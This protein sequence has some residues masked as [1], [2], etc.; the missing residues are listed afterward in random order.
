MLSLAQ[1]GH[2]DLW[3]GTPD[4]L[5]HV[6]ANGQ[7][8]KTYTS[9]DGLPDDFIRSLLVDSQGTVWAGTRRGLA[10]LERGRI[11]VL[12]R[13]AGLPSDSIGPLL[14]SGPA[15]RG[16]LWIGS[17]GGLA[18]LREGGGMEVTTPVPEGDTIITAL[19][20]DGAGGLWV[21]VHGKGLFRWLTG[22]FTPVA[23]P[24]LPSEIT[25][26]HTDQQG[27]L[28]IRSP[29]AVYRVQAS[30]LKAC[31]GGRSCS[32]LVDEF[33]AADGMP[34]DALAAE[35]TPQI[36]EVAGGELWFSTRKG[37]AVT[38]PAHLPRRDK[39]P[40]VVVQRLTVDGVAEPVGEGDLRIGPG[41]NRYVFDYAALSFRLPSKVRYRYRLDGF[42]R[43]WVD[44]GAA[45][46]AYYT[47]LPPGRYRFRVLAANENGL[48]TDP[49][50]ALI[51]RVL[52]PVYRRWW[53]YV[54]VLLLVAAL[55]FATLRL[56]DRAVQRRFA[57]VLEERNRMAREIHDTLAQ[58]FV[59]VTLQLD[60]ASGHLRGQRYEQAAL[61]LQS[62]R[63]LVK[64]GLQAARQSIWNLRANAGERSLPTRLSIL[65]ARYSFGDRSPKVSIGGAF[66][67]LA[68]ALEDEVLR[69]A[70]ESLSNAERHA[71]ASE[72]N[73]ELRYAPDQL[74]LRVQDNG[75]GFSPE[76]GLHAEGHYGVRGMY[77]RAAALGGELRMVSSPGQGTTVSLQVPLRAREV[78]NS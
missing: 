25:A 71:G 14:E 10:R 63:T 52:P 70:G 40:P 21:G 60:I 29:Q 39:R 48:W 57:L 72:V 17:S 66:R 1:G 3:V 18:R 34:S 33:G 26:L 74:L 2:G 43:E 65:A 41:H 27:F 68:P 6:A 30:A 75:R 55:V 16:R 49:G 77:E 7:V 8:Q 51:L 23:A 24:G 5:N 64:E 44:A 13:S 15:P 12:T 56:R 67:K 38:D 31:V 45:R 46:S 28:W 11:T 78:M 4:G 42:D 22:Q 36:T 37:I 54:L 62:T 58:D 19:G 69:I 35:G 9:A 47:G 20:S 76:A 50:A 73:V 32:A 61:Q 59:S 53:F